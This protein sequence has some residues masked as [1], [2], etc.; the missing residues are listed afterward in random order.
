MPGIP[1]TP[2][3][4][5]LSPPYLI[6]KNRTSPDAAGVRLKCRSRRNAAPEH[7]CHRPIF[8]S[9][10]HLLCVRFIPFPALSH[11]CPRPFTSYL[12]RL[13]RSSLTF[14]TS[15]KR[16]CSRWLPLSFARA[17]PLRGH[18][19]TSLLT[20]L[21]LFST[22]TMLRSSLPRNSHPLIPLTT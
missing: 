9:C 11:P 6:I 12:S 2:A 8:P 4:C 1:H 18:G 22:V 13:R 7:A 10:L 20:T 5:K 16:A 14:T 19:R 21:G 17:L 15:R 3:D